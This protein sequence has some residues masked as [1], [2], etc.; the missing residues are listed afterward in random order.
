MLPAADVTQLK[1]FT[2]S[3][4]QRYIL[5]IRSV[6]L[7]ANHDVLMTYLCHSAESHPGGISDHVARPN[8]D[9]R[10]FVATSTHRRPRL[11]F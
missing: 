9:A 10:H 8:D 4:L 11:S 2:F 1:A 6:V 5:V 7:I 3:I